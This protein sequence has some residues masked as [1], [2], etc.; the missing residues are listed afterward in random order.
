MQE[1]TYKFQLSNMRVTAVLPHLSA[2]LM[3]KRYAPSDTVKRILTVHQHASNE[4]FFITRGSLAVYC[5]EDVY[6]TEEGGIILPP[7]YYHYTVPEGAEGYVLNFSI[8]P[9]D[10]EKTGLFEQVSACIAQKPFCFQLTE[11]IRFYVKKIGECVEKGDRDEDVPHLL[12]LLFSSLFH[13]VSPLASKETPAATKRDGYLVTIEDYIARHYCEPIRLPELAAE[14]FLCPRQVSRIIMQEYGCSLSE[15]VNRRRLNV[16]A[17]L[18]DSTNLSVA[19][20]ASSVGYLQE[21]HFYAR[22]RKLYGISPLAFREENRKKR[23]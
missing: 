17:S 22:F 9:L 3:D 13:T 12:A 8:E 23:R 1:R 21:S 19:E 10:L 16:A 15:L 20:I 14:L 4:I 2:F 11:D 18:L 5:G 7:R 6:R